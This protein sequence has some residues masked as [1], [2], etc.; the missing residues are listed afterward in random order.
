MDD[1]EEALL[2][3]LNSTPL[4]AGT[5][6]ELLADEADQGTR[7]ARSLGGRGSRAE[8]DHL[9]EARGW[10]QSSVRTG[11]IHPDLLNTLDGVVQRPVSLTAD[12]LRWEL[13]GPPAR[14]PAARLV[15]AWAELVKSRPGRLRA[16]QN[17]ECHLFLID[18]SKGNSARWCS[19][20]TCGNRM[21][22]RRHHSR[23]AG[24]TPAGNEQ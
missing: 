8:V 2:A 15:I 5:E 9:V 13:D 23:K 17:A 22:A 1:H 3:L 10:L 6:R 4:E 20:A 24:R 12:G 19:M 11:A 14:L 7:I 21:K 18:H 16:C